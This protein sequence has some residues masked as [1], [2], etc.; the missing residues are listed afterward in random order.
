MPTETNPRWENE[1][2]PTAIATV[3]VT[4]PSLLIFL[5]FLALNLLLHVSTLPLLPLALLLLLCPILRIT[6]PSL[7]HHLFAPLQNY[8][9]DVV[10]HVCILAPAG[11]AEVLGSLDPLDL[12]PLLSRQGALEQL[13][14]ARL[15]VLGGAHERR[16]NLQRLERVVVQFLL[17]MEKRENS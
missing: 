5:R 13:R 3:C 9:V 10:E 7:A 8:F 6:L 17:S 2:E 11:L 14:V 12:D 4:F 15:L 1:Q 16:R